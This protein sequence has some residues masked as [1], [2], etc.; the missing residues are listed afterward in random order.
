M[1]IKKFS[2]QEKRDL[3]PVALDQSALMEMGK[4]VSGVANL[5]CRVRDARGDWFRLTSHEDFI[6]LDQTASRELKHVIMCAVRQDGTRPLSVELCGERAQLRYNKDSGEVLQA[7]EEIL[8]ISRSRARKW[9]RFALERSVVGHVFVVLI[10]AAASLLISAIVGAKLSWWLLP[11]TVVAT[12]VLVPACKFILRR[13]VC[14]AYIYNGPDQ[15]RPG[16]FRRNKDALGVTLMGAVA[17]TA[18]A[19][20]A[21]LL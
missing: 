2:L 4:A 16:F 5:D 7:A 1:S 13:V 15:E 12:M 21:R 17:V 20:L 9:T 10:A 11:A 14:H 18:L 19:L 3:P 8:G 6:N